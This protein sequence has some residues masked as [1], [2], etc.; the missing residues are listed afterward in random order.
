MPMKFVAFSE[1][2]V[3]EWTETKLLATKDLALEFRAAE[4]HLLR[5]EADNYATQAQL[6]DAGAH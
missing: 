1:R 6:Y 5:R 2:K 3:N 4:L